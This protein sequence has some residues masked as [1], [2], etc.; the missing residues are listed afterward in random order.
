MDISALLVALKASNGKLNATVN[1]MSEP[2]GKMTDLFF[3]DLGRLASR[4]LNV[5]GAEG[6]DEFLYMVELAGVL[7]VARV[8]VLASTMQMSATRGTKYLTVMHSPSNGAG[9][10]WN[11]YL[12]GESSNWQKGMG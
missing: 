10:I 9:I 6:K 8:V 4:S 12:Q 1:D 2:D 5:L 7:L 3:L 11:S